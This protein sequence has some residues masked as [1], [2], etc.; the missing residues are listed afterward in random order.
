MITMPKAMKDDKEYYY[1]RVCNKVK[2]LIEDTM[3]EV[4]PIEHTIQRLKYV[5]D[6]ADWYSECVHL[7]LSLYCAY[8]NAGAELF[9]ITEA[10]HSAMDEALAFYK[11]FN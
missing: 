9:K 8:D 2:D 3:Q 10:A 7:E 5:A 1:L 4:W 6:C 11:S